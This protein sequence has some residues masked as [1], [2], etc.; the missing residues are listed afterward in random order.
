MFVM[1]LWVCPPT[2]INKCNFKMKKEMGPIYLLFSNSALREFVIPTKWKVISPTLR[3][4]NLQEGSSTPWDCSL[5]EAGEGCQSQKGSN[6]EEAHREGDPEPSSR[7][8]G[9]K[10]GETGKTKVKTWSS[11]PPQPDWG[12][13]R[14]CAAFWV[15]AANVVGFVAVAAVRWGLTV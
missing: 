8:S 7:E 5:Q 4:F 3:T 6:L 12:T 11:T 15:P 10:D 1:C 2:Q 9:G 13:R 14:N